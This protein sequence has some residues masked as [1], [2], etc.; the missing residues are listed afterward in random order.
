M[1]IC[2]DIVRDLGPLSQDTSLVH[3]RVLAT[4]DLHATL[5][6]FDYFA[7]RRDDTV[8]LV[9]IA[10][11]VEAARADA[12]NSILVDN[13]DTFQGGALGDLAARDVYV[14]DAPHPMI[15]A[16]NA[17]NYDAATLGNHD[18]DFGISPL[19]RVLADAR[20]PVVLANAHSPGN[21]KP[22]RPR[23]T[24]LKREV[25]DLD[26]TPHVL[27]IGVT[28]TVPPQ[29][30]QWNKSILNGDLIFEDAVEAAA[31]EAR[32][33][34]AAGADIV[35]VLSHSGLGEP[36]T[37]PSGGDSPDT[38]VGAENVA[39]R[40][41]ALPEVD[42]V[43]AGHTHEVYPRKCACNIL[44]PDTPIVQP[45]FWGSHLGC[46]DIAIS[47][48]RTD[49]SQG[50]TV[51][52]AHAEALPLNG[53]TRDASNAAL[54]GLL[55]GK[56][57]LRKTIGAQHRATRAATG[58]QIGRSAVA[59]HTF[60]SKLTPC[61]AT[62]IMSDAQ[63]AAARDLLGHHADLRDLPLVSAVAPMRS[64][65][66]TGPEQ[67]TDIP[68]GPLLFR[69]VADLYCY[70]NALS[71]LRLRGRDISQWLERAA[72]LFERIDPDE[73]TLQPLINHDFAG[74]NFDRLDGLTYDI[75]VSM[76][77]RTD[78]HGEHVFDTPGRIGNLRHADGR[79][80]DPAEEVLVVTNSYR[81]SGGGNFPIC[82]AS[83]VVV[84]DTDL[85]RDIIV[86]FIKARAEPIDPTP[87]PNFTLR[88][89]G[90]ARPVFETGPG[91]L[92]HE[93]ELARIGLSYLGTSEDGFAQ[94]EYGPAPGAPL[95]TALKSGVM[96]NN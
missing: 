21:G 27:C 81:A 71:V 16:M 1:S 88:G 93:A 26:G 89:F 20:F 40:I 90:K 7:D 79:P 38:S 9:R 85:L 47:R 95:T 15:T 52:K 64:G 66:R 54:K 35:V 58:R 12:P 11:L 10:G 42:M 65:G 5:M 75:D 14:T 87:R 18:F 57:D 77:A 24:M 91:A 6:P 84:S 67:F 78:P 68:A 28:G 53:T 60:F 83:D 50:W 96:L 59:L 34:K 41:A 17:L 82:A 30:A 48:S 86:N 39:R 31:R 80:V 37:A 4:T 56:S 69:H 51:L 36:S 8:G 2:R 92:R 61:R 22:F 19:R 33:L 23:H 45:G 74:Y 44:P 13:G 43:V 3:L 76:P 32:L 73:A 63:M 46:I 62:Q 49:P 72:S 55:R 29:V 25:E 94:F 70:P